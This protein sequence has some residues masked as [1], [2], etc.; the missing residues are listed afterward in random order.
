M[1]STQSFAQTRIFA[2]GR[3]RSIGKAI[4]I[5][6]MLNRYTHTK[7]LILLILLSGQACAATEITVHH[8]DYD[9]CVLLIIDGLGSSYCYPEFT[10]YALDHSIPGRADCMNLLAIANNGTRVIDVRA[11]KTSTSPG[12]SVIVTGCADAN[13]KTVEEGRTI[14]DIAHENGYF[15]AGV[16][17]TGDFKEMRDELDVILHLQ[18]NSINRPGIAIDSHPYGREGV[19]RDIA[20]LMEKWSNITQYLGDKKGVERYIA[21]N[22][23]ALDASDAIIRDMCRSDLPFIMIIN[24]GAVDSA[25][26]YLGASGYPEVINGTDDAIME[27]Y[28]TCAD[29]NLLFILTADHGMGFAAC[30]AYHGGHASE[31]YAKH[32]ESQRIP[33]VFRGSGIAESVIA[34]GGQEDIAPTLLHQM[35]MPDIS[36]DGVPLP[37]GRYADLRI[38][39]GA[40]ADVEVHGS[41]S[42]IK[43]TSDSEFL[44]RGL[45]I[46]CNYTILITR[47]GKTD[48]HEIFLDSDCVVDC[49][50]PGKIVVSDPIERTQKTQKNDRKSILWV[51]VPIIIINLV[52][53]SLIIKTMRE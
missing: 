5:S 8:T 3:M 50:V 28:R 47:N 24:V 22:E 12:H 9:G 40:D 52:G 45:D 51:A 34:S 23:W 18:N 44:F 32:P 36:C 26:H 19:S 25:G 30:D 21:Y 29:H 48:E 7:I 17:E 11:P 6:C 4:L 16:M 35:D 15:C 41:G 1:P 43:G 2:D 27:L 31:K 33:L 46:N 49:S 39:T 38:L 20:G 14:F 37:V 42:I 13:P 10:P 53:I